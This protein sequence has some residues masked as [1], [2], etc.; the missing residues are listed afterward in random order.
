VTERK[1]ERKKESLRGLAKLEAC[2][3]RRQQHD[4]TFNALSTL[5]LIGIA[6]I[7]NRNHPTQP[8]Q[9]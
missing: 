1:K 3:C 8:R 6:E 4:S 2:V 7:L 9:G 5:Q